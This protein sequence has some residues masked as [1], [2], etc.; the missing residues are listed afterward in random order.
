MSTGYRLAFG[1]SVFAS[2]YRT[3]ELA[4]ASLDKIEALD[5]A[6]GTRPKDGNRR[7]ILEGTTPV[8]IRF[9]VLGQ[10]ITADLS[11]EPRK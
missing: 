9:A 5:L 4:S 11:T 3:R 2:W 6:N 8:E 1:K 7:I 10:W